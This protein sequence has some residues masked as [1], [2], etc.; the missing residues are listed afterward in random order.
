M[1]IKKPILILG[2]IAI[3]LIFYFIG[4][5]A[6]TKK[7]SIEDKYAD[8]NSTNI[9]EGVSEQSPKPFGS[10][11][12]YEPK[13]Q[14]EDFGQTNSPKSATA[15]QDTKVS[16]S[17]NI[18]SYALETLTYI[19]KHDKAPE[20]YVGGRQF[21]NREQILPK[22]SGDGNKISYREWDVHPKKNGV[23][24]GAERLV[25]GSDGRNY[26]TEDHYRSFVEIK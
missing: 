18:P 2:G 10:S 21:F 25:T 15:S 6:S 9:A 3:G 20:G 16:S 19:L 24:R 5:F 8:T 4:S 14:V 22:T 17:S 13:I 23:N 11:K 26:F 12:A 7:I 1:F